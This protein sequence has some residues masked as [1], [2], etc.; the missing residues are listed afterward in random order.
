MKRGIILMGAAMTL[1][2]G[3]PMGHNNST[4]VVTRIHTVSIHVR[5]HVVH[6]AV[7]RFLRED[8]QL[9]LVYEPV[10]QGERKYVGFWAGNLVL[11]P[12]GPYSNISYA[13]PDFAAIFCGLTFEAYTSSEES[14][15]QLES[16]SLSHKP[17][18]AFVIIND[19]NLVQGNLVASIM[20]N[21]GRR[22]EAQK[23]E[24]L[25]SQLKEDQGGPLGIQYVSEIQVGYTRGQDV[26]AWKVFLAPHRQAHR[27]Q[28]PLGNGPAIHLMKG[29]RKEIKAVVFKV[30]SLAA[31]VRY[32]KANNLLGP[33]S[34]KQVQVKA[35]DHWEFTL[36]LQE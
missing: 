16:R 33:T 31:A 18:G 32:L 36:I 34:K 4:P 5:D 17:L 15:E 13:T 22:Q 2:A 21:P 35:P 25:S 12:C 20:D 23:H 8:L 11:E 3:C 14:R 19:P 30:R 7:A 29:D 10:T 27:Y 28:W 9:P 24:A 6:D 1:M 26:D